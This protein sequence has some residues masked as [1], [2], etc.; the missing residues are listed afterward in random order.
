MNLK[1]LYKTYVAPFN[2]VVYFLILLFI[3]HF[4]WKICIDGDMRDNY[5]YFFNKNITPEWLFTA[6]EWLTQAAAWFIRL[7]PNT[8]SLVVGKTNLYFPDGINTHI[9]WGC[10]G[11]KQMFIFCGIMIF[12]RLFEIRKFK[13]IKETRSWNISIHFP[14]FNRNKWWY[15]PL[16][17]IVLTIYNI[18]RIG[19]ISLLTRGNPESFDSLHDGIFRIL[20]YTI[21]FLL[22]VVWEEVFVKKKSKN[23]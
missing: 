19:S 23:A 1:K 8:D 12:Y 2:S 10:T 17:C 16:G 6:N 5:M 20:Y 3:F 13:R 11:I 14:R 15:I 4:S 21:V 18:I 22:W 7:F 9:I